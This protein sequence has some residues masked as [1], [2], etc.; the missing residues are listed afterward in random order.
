MNFKQRFYWEVYQQCINNNTK[1]WIK[2]R[3]P[4]LKYKSDAFFDQ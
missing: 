4:I 3:M 1:M 2:L